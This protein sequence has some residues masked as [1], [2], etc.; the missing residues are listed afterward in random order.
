MAVARRHHTVPRTYLAR[1]AD[2]VG[3][4]AGVELTGKKP[5]VA[6]IKDASVVNN[7]YTVANWSVPPDFVEHWMNPIEAGFA[8]IRD[9]IESGEWPLSADHRHGLARFIALQ[10]RRGPNARRLTEMAYEE[11]LL[12]IIAEEGKACIP[13]VVEEVTGTTATAAVIEDVWSRAQAGEPPRLEVMPEHHANLMVAGLE[14]LAAI[15][16]D[17]RWT[18]YSFD[19]GSLLT[20]DAPITFLAPVIEPA[21]N[22]SSVSD[23]AGWAF[24][25]TRQLG[26]HALRAGADEADDC[27]RGDDEI[28]RKFNLLTAHTAERF[29][30]HHPDDLGLVPDGLRDPSDDGADRIRIRGRAEADLRRHRELR[31][32]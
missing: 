2:D 19:A 21:A 17:S 16:L 30:F 10:F 14:D 25:L 31:G 12:Q 6:N 22:R 11:M 32:P 13:K 9:A 5:F 20:S 1:F 4:L 24:P 29:I 23:S 27:Y 26:V 8:E 28:A 7:F 3:K 18:L 15:V